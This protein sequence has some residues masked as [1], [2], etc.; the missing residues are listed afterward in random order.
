VIRT[1]VPG[2]AIPGLLELGLPVLAQDAIP[3]DVLTPVQAVE[4]GLNITSLLAAPSQLTLAWGHTGREVLLARASTS[5]I[6]VTVDVG[7]W[8]LDQ[9]VSNFPPVTLTS[10]SLYSFGPFHSL[11]AGADTVMQ[12]TLSATTGI[13]VALLR[14]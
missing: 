10:G 9:P 12:A 6:T 1:A 4:T 11:V 13:T 2:L 14:Y 3:V 5:G 7:T 8:I